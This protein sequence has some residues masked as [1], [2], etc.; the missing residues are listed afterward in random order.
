MK[1]E[2]LTIAFAY[3]GVIVGAGLSSGQDLMQYF[4]SFG[5]IGLLGALLLGLLNVLFG[6]IIIT[7]GSYYQSS[8]HKEVFEHIATP[9][10][11]RIIDL[12][13]IISSFVMGFVMIAGA[14]ANLH[15]QFDI[16][17]WSG[18]LF[19]SL[20]VIVVSFLDF[21]KITNV[22]GIFTPV[23]IVIIFGM[24]LY[25][26]WTQPV[27]IHGMDQAAKSLTP[28]LPNVW[29]S[30]FNYF[31]LCVLTGVS[32]AFVLG[33]S[34]VRIG[35]AEKGGTIGGV[36]IGVVI[37]CATLTLF[38]NM[39]TATSA[40][41]PMLSIINQI[42][43]VLALFYAIVIFALIFNT[44][45]SLFYGLAKRFAGE[46]QKKLQRWMIGIVALGFL[47]SFG[48]FKSLVS[49][50]YPIL[51]Y[52]GFVL[53]A[54]LLIAWIKRK[55]NIYREKM[56]RRKMIRL[57]LK[58]HDENRD[59]TKKDQEQFEKLSEMSVADTKTLQE[60]IREYAHEIINSPVDENEFAK[61]ELEVEKSAISSDIQDRE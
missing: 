5:K 55:G 19:C 9:I 51:G 33:G 37:F 6:K 44:S 1:K 15:Q 43:P 4:I 18:A 49:K 7:L 29:L 17:S 48:G 13:L 58:K 45:F 24:M 42:H 12:T 36:L 2:S 34:I 59:Y 39:D 16:P 27:D 41:I 20:L 26:L 8:N 61:K 54:V 50:M 23:I 30:V 14:G 25:S 47:C 57:H 32:M 40:E 56:L 35:V 28:A 3:V 38:L 53:L 46:N 22:L 10:L 31:S 21:E 11:N 52:M 60:D